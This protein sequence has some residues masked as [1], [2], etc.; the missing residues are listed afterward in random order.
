MNVSTEIDEL[1]NMQR[2]AKASFPDR[3]FVFFGFFLN[4]KQSQD[5]KQKKRGIEIIW[6]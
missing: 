3:F 4:Q 1:R 2:V 5:I 6:L